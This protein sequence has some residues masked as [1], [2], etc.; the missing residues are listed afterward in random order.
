MIFLGCV[1]G[2]VSPEKLNFPKLIINLKALVLSR[3]NLEKNKN[4]IQKLM[5]GHW[6]NVSW[7][8]LSKHIIHIHVAWSLIFFKNYSFKEQALVFL[9][10]LE[11]VLILPLESVPGISLPRGV[12]FIRK[13]HVVPLF[14]YFLQPWDQKTII[15]SSDIEF[16]HSKELSVFYNF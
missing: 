2:K 12:N 10:T 5:T 15:F 1:S 6:R 7:N 8:Q 4:A 3:I 11:S 14:F 9:W 13:H 16:K